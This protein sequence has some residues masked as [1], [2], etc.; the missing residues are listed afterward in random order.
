MFHCSRCTTLLLL[1]ITYNLLVSAFHTAKCPVA[2][3]ITKDNQ[4]DSTIIVLRDA[5]D[6]GTIHQLCVRGCPC[7]NALN[8]GCALETFLCVHV[9]SALNLG[10]ALCV[11]M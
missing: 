7:N 11:V 9:V 4:S 8:L 6:V 2:S 3:A 1:L 5:K 10:C